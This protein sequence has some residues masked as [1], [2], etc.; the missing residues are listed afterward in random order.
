[1]S[2]KKLI[3]GMRFT[4]KVV[5]QILKDKKNKNFCCFLNFGQ[6]S[7]DFN[8]IVIKAKMHAKIYIFFGAWKT[9]YD[10]LALRYLVEWT[11]TFFFF[12]F[13]FLFFVF[14]KSWRKPDILIPEL[15]FYD[16]KDR[17]ILSKKRERHKS[18]VG[19]SQIL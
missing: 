17:P 5:P 6:H 19:K 10:F 8:K 11:K 3:Y 7:C 2:K 1:M 9:Q 16:V 4:C 14:F 12:F 13:K 18:K 15:N